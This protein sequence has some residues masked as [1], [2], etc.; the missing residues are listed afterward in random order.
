M[1]KLMF[2]VIVAIVVLGAS[3]LFP[4]LSSYQQPPQ[5]ITEEKVSEIKKN[6][7]Y[8]VEIT[9][10]PASLT[11]TTNRSKLGLDVGSSALHFGI[12]PR[13]VTSNKLIKLHNGNEVPVKVSLKAYGSISSLVKMEENF[14]L[15][16]KKSKT[17]TVKAGEGKAGEYSGEVQII[18]KKPENRWAEWLLPLV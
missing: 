10:L 8:R 14:I 3:I 7:F 4:V 6:L 13:N 9:R 1:N 16:P 5:R 18:I 17:I 11:I 15:A 12:V 2:T